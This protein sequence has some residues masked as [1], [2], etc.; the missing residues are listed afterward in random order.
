MTHPFNAKISMLAFPLIFRPKIL[1]YTQHCREFGFRLCA[2]HLPP[3][4][5]WR[6]CHQCL[7]QIYIL[8][9]CCLKVGL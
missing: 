8:V 6:L 4:T 1:R 7:V 5:L 9:A 3:G 2:G